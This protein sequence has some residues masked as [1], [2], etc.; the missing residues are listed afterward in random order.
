MSASIL[1]IDTSLFISWV[2]YCYLC[3][4][5][6]KI[7]YSPHL[8]MSTCSTWMTLLSLAAI[9]PWRIKWFDHYLSNCQY[10]PG[11]LIEGRVTGTEWVRIWGY[12]SVSNR[13]LSILNQPLCFVTSRYRLS[14]WR[15]AG[16]LARVPKLWLLMNTALACCKLI[17]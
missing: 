4:H 6:N 14:N 3:H 12:W 7:K 9:D 16:V 11:V 8:L 17:H 13:P 15:G 2:R 10:F 5:G 1:Y